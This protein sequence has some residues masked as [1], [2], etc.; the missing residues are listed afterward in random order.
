MINIIKDI[1][2]ITEIHK[3]D[4]ILIGTNIKN[5]LIHGFQS[6]IAQKYKYI[7]EE[8]K[9][10]RYDDASKIG[11]VQ[12]VIGNESDPIFAI[13]YIFK[14]RYRPDIK[15]DA[16]DYEGLRKCLSLINK[17]FKGKKIASTIMGNSEYEGGGDKD[18]I[19]NIFNEEMKDVDVT[20]YDYKQND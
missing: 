17:H 5:L 18:K 3:Y 9:K 11:T 8:N 7:D 12:V 6:A 4:V 16:L 14:G 10:T 1:D 20:L 19:L 15:P 13:C 2:L